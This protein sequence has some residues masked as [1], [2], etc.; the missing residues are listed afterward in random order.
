MENHVT[1]DVIVQ[2]KIYLHLFELS[3]YVRK[4]CK[5][6]PHLKDVAAINRVI[7]YNHNTMDYKITYT[8]LMLVKMNL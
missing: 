1:Y 5:I 2:N 4:F 7:K 6:S 3:L 8:D